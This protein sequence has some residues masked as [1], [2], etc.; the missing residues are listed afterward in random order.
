M[1]NGVV[2]GFMDFLG[3]VGDGIH[4]VAK[5]MG[6]DESVGRM[7][8]DGHTLC[9]QKGNSDFLGRI[10]DVRAVAGC[11]DEGVAVVHTDNTYAFYDM[12]GR[13]KGA[14]LSRD[15]FFAVKDKMPGFFNKPNVNV[16]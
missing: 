3:S 10:R 16:D 7:R 6:V 12:H 4:T 13:I 2:M 15:E 14:L 9:L 1:H 11:G 8:M 5:F